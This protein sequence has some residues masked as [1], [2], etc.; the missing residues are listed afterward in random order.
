LKKVIIYSPV[1]ESAILFLNS[2]LEKFV[3]NNIDVILISN[4]NLH[5]G[6]A[7][8]TKKF[9][10]FECKGNNRNPLT[11]LSDISLFNSF[12][13]KE[14]LIFNGSSTI[15]LSFLLKILKPYNKNI[16]ILHGTLKSKGVIINSIFISFLF[17]AS[18]IG[19]EIF[20]VN[21]RFKRFFLRK[22]KFHFLGIAGVGINKS[23]INNLKNN[24]FSK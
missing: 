11:L 23:A 3:D 13:K 7:I 2:T 4:P 18:T 14:L 9:K 20:S 8:P 15:F 16:F 17:L 22:S 6:F 10:T 21:N 1:Q 5:L 19:V 24:Y 12:K